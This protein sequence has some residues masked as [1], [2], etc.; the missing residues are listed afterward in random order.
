MGYKDMRGAIE[1]IIGE[2]KSQ[3][4]DEQIL[5]IYHEC[6]L[7]E[8]FRIFVVTMKMNVF[9]AKGKTNVTIDTII[10]VIMVG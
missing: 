3:E 2:K 7:R 5:Q 6:K 8:I 1:G 10:G 4:T 9:L